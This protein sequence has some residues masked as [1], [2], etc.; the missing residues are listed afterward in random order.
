MRVLTLIVC[1]AMF[2]QG[3]TGTETSTPESL[4]LGEVDLD[5]SG[6]VPEIPTE[7]GGLPAELPGGIPVPGGLPSIPSLPGV[8]GLFSF[9][10]FEIPGVPTA[11]EVQIPGWDDLS[12][13]VP[14]LPDVPG[15]EPPE[16]EVT[17]EVLPDTSPLPPI[18]Y[19]TEEPPMDSVVSPAGPDSADMVDWVPE[20]LG[21]PFLSIPNFGEGAEQASKEYLRCRGAAQT[22]AEG[23]VCDET[24]TEYL[25]Y[26]LGVSLP[27]EEEAD[28][29]VVTDGY[30]SQVEFDLPV[31]EGG[32]VSFEEGVSTLSLPKVHFGYTKDHEAC[33]EA[34]YDCPH[35]VTFQDVMLPVTFA[36]SAQEG[37][38]EAWDTFVKNLA[39]D[40]NAQ[41]NTKPYCN[42]NGNIYC[43]FMAF[44]GPPIPDPA[45][46]M[47]R[48][49][50]S[51]I[52]DLP[53]RQAEYWADVSVALATNLP[54]SVPWGGV[55]LPV[56]SVTTAPVF[57]LNPSYEQ[58][59]SPVTDD[60]RERLYYLQGLFVA[61]YP[62]VPVP[63]LPGDLTE[64]MPG[65]S[66][67]EAAKPSWEPATPLEN[68]DFGYASLYKVER[69]AQFSFI[70]DMGKLNPGYVFY[71]DAFV[72]DI[73][74]FK[75]PLPVFAPTL[76]ALTSYETVAEGGYISDVVGEPYLFYESN[77]A[78][79]GGDDEE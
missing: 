20:D 3:Q 7:L 45:C 55:Y 44:T 35:P 74:F 11:G 67:L 16:E 63:V 30:V 10:D 12:A 57:A 5:L 66:P 77:P 14:G 27:P 56:A 53:V 70:A 28:E 23:A 51:L 8:G 42:L 18:D 40:I 54:N 17:E 38:D 60:P 50:Q 47:L 34:M 26:A 46:L 31:F 19:G 32:G 65:L 71:C 79:G 49:A 25:D 29:E 61:G 72:V 37:I 73:P 58:Y 78:E 43:L 1:F 76:K 41:I 39:G 22:V 2:A 15:W 68:Q 24:Y 4:N 9:L 59:F 33:A 48:I 64:G 6:W 69:K 75:I 62:D 36:E 52:E 13:Q 21:V